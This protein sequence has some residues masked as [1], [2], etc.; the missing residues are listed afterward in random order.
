MRH[1]NN[2]AQSCATDPSPKRQRG[3]G[4]RSLALPAWKEWRVNAYGRLAA[5]FAALTLG[6]GGCFLPGGAKPDSTRGQSPKQRKAGPSS[7]SAGPLENSA[8]VRLTV[9]GESVEPADLWRDAPPAMLRRAETL[10]PNAYQ[11]FV[12]QAAAQLIRD[13]MA[14]MLLNQV[15]SL[16][17]P[18]ELQT[19]IDEIA[20]GEIR[21]I[22]ARDFG[23]VQHRYE[24]DLHGRGQTLDDVRTELAREIIIARYL[25]I[26]VKPKVGEP[27]RAELLAA[28]QNNQDQWRRPPRRSMAL[29]D[30]RVLD[31]LPEGVKSPTRKQQD[32]A[33]E[34]ARAIAQTAWTEI[35]SGVDFADVAKRYS[36]GLHA[37]EGGEWGWV[38]SEA[39]R[40]RFLPAVTTLQELRQGEVSE[41]IETP[42]SFFL[43]LCS[44]FDPGVEP[45]F[46]SVQ[47]ALKEQ[48][49]R[50]TY[51][52]LIGQLV[53]RLQAK[54]RI[55]PANLELFHA[56]V[57]AAAPKPKNPGAP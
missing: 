22:V 52:R 26:E 3:V 6:L 20:D 12:E 35:E 51:N 17:Q 54:A 39:V 36:D 40:E 2:R 44:R 34:A 29:I 43:V 1:P 14:E 8:E 46:Q 57:V 56:A 55:E 28:F 53:N 21:K 27:S 24:K 10:S 38:S 16:D 15:A 45:D 9:N 42:D 5:L 30:V 31:H 11:Q 7:V 37:P 25:E 18:P 41:I 50:M 33:R 49:F 32:A 23:G 13:K 47:P 48:H 19:R 4:N